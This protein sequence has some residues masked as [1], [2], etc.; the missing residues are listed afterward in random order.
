M[1]PVCPKSGSATTRRSRAGR[2][3]PAATILVPS[4]LEYRFRQLHPGAV[5]ADPVSAEKIDATERVMGE[6][7]PIK[8]IAGVERPGWTPVNA[9]HAES[10]EATA[11]LTRTEDPLFLFFTSG[12]TGLPKVVTHTHASY[13]IGHLTTSAWIGVLPGD[14]HSNISQAGWAKFAW[15]SFFAPWN[16]GA[17]SFAYHYSGRFDA[18]HAICG[19]SKTI[20]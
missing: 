4:D 19:R 9:S 14:V 8:L 16:V 11:A 6:S 7:I 3:R 17:T 1:L 15:S 5:L 13:P 12:T 10:P 20:G 2:P 18:G